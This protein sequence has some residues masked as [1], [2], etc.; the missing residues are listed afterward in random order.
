M[1][2]VERTPNAARARVDEWKAT[3][4]EKGF[5]EVEGAH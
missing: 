4:I 3:A 2:Q 5:I 1:S